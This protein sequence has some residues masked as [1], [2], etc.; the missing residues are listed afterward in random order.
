MSAGDDSLTVLVH[1]Y[2]KGGRD[3]RPLAR[4]LARLGRRV[5]IADLPATFGS[6][7]RCRGE[8]ERFLD[9]VA[10][11]AQTVHLVGHS[12]GGLV[13]RAYLAANKAERVGRCVLIGTPNRGARL[14]DLGLDRKS[15]V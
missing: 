9:S 15:V 1:G 4:N 11:D 13:I 7:D 12:F 5:A 10:A 8:F 14:A 3:M 2:F 6:L